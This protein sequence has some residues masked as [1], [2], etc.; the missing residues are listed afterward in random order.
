MYISNIVMSRNKSFLIGKNYTIVLTNIYINT[1]IFTKESIRVKITTQMKNALVS[2][3][4][5]LN[6]KIAPQRELGS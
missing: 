5:V 1:I 6:R 3:D 4:D 2:N